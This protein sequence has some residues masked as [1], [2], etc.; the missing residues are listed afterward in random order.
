MKQNNKLL[1]LICNK[2]R[3]ELINNILPTKFLLPLFS[4]A[5]L[6]CLRLITVTTAITSL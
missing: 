2:Y 6:R 5:S 1:K 3:F 4:R